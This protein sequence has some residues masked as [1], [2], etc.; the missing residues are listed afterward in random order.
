MALNNLKISTRLLLLTG[1]ALLVLAGSGVFGFAVMTRINAV[2][3]E[4]IAVSALVTASV[5]EA[6]SAQ[7]A[8]KKQVQEWK[9]LLLRG[10]D[11]EKY[12]SYVK[13]FQQE[14]A[15]VVRLLTQLKATMTK[16]RFPTQTIDSAI[17]AHVALT[18]Q[19]EDALKAIPPS[20]PRFSAL[21]DQKVQGIDREPTKV[22]DDIVED[23]TA[24][25]AKVSQTAEASA[26]ELYDRTLLL[27][28]LGMVGAVAVT[29]LLS[30]TIIRS[31]TVPLGRSVAYAE[32]IGQGR[33]DARL[34]VA[35]RDEI[36]VL[37]GAMRAMVASLQ[38]KMAFS[39]AKSREAAEEAAKARQAMEQAAAEARRAEE[40]RTALLA[41][42]RQLEDVAAVVASASETLSEQS[43][44]ASQG[45]ATQAARIDET[46]T[47]MEEMN[48][49]VLEVAKNAGQASTSADLARGKAKEGAVVVAEVVSGIEAVRTQALALKNDV[50]G[51]GRQSE[52]IGAILDVIA[53]IADQTNLLALNAAIEAARA[54]DAGRGFAVVAD[55]VRKLAEKTMSATAEVGQA[56]RAIQDGTR[57]NI[58]NVDAAGSAIEAATG[59]A[60][61]SG[62]VLEAM[63]SFVD[64]ATEQVSSIAAA[65]EQQSATSEEINRSL[66]DI[67]RIAGETSTIMERSAAA[68]GDLNRQ[69]QVLKKLIAD[70]QRAG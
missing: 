37:A 5:D 49:T 21:V 31:I 10:H 52:G 46:A 20:D 41:T 61:A 43:A 16:L 7:V 32:D 17:A 45:A 70:M 54:G 51:L 57:Q 42:A 36:G 47:A 12:Q 56:I 38:E 55:E 66:G 48:A 3:M 22:I 14:H 33:L 28:I 44:Q 4:N 25:A 23:I 15:E 6:R 2:S 63:V 65:A 11:P 8:F 27:A 19:Y 40:S 30:M 24:S 67:S 29:G 9:N 39:E 58:R 50:D 62:Q 1:T 69:T 26:R 64:R 53:D 34:E 59:K 68:V 13:L 18:R 60:G 35:G